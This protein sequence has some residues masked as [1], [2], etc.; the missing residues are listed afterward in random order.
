MDFNFTEEQTLLE[1]M[2]TS[3]VRD[4]YPWEARE[5]IVKTE[6]GWKPENWSQFA[7]LGLLGVPFA[8]EFGGLG[9]SVVDTMIVMEQFGKGL[10]VE[11]YMPSVVLAGG[12]I[13]S[14]GSKEQVES[15]IPNIISGDVRYAFA[16]SEPQ[17]RFD[18]FDVKTSAATDGDD[19]ILNGFKSVVFGGPI[20]TH[21]IIS[22]RTSGDQRDTNGITLFLVDKKSEGLTLQNYPTIDEYRASEVVIENLKVS[23]DMVLGEVDNAYNAIDENIDRSTIAVCAE[24]VGI[25][26]VL[27]DATIDYCKN[28]KQFGQAI[29]KNQSIQHRLVDMMI[30]YEQSKSILYMA[31]TSNLSDPTSRK[32]AVSAAK[33]R[34]G[35]A[36]K[37]VGENSI[38]L[39]GG[40]GMVDEYLVSHYF[41]RATMLG[42]LFGNED[43]HMKRFSDITQANVSKITDSNTSHIT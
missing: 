29:G 40:M 38:Q 39:H 26:E 11:P 20:A 43:Y 31:C 23:K 9:G 41:K 28:R 25:L 6:E 8:E 1:N 32:K 37:Y 17:S 42:V 21:L 2:V 12:L 24:A 10:V 16:H 14:L 34:I 19:F 5:A 35:K 13:S 30:E 18:L 33:A 15:I 4:N 36:I 22:A 3:F 7:E 27:K